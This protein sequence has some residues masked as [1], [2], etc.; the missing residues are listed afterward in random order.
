M[1][2][3]LKQIICNDIFTLKRLNFD[4]IKKSDYITYNLKKLNRQ[5]SKNHLSK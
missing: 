1:L 5:D 3:Y 4:S 2:F